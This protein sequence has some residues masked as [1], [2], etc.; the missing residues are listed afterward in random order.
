MQHA[1]MGARGSQFTVLQPAVKSPAVF[2]ISLS[3]S[4][5]AAFALGLHLVDEK[6]LA[7]MG[8]PL[9][10][11][12]LLKLWSKIYSESVLI[13]PSLGLQV[14]TKNY[15]GHVC[16]QFFCLSQIKDI[17]INEAITMNSVV[18]YLVVLLNDVDSSGQQMLHPL[19]IHTWPTSGELQQVYQV[20]QVKLLHAHSR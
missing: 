16:T 19:F 6:S 4:L 2:W 18:T 15:L 17:V 10:A 8:L 3:A 20:S 11:G 1:D 12:I 14:K 7:N 13:L 9:M 5:V